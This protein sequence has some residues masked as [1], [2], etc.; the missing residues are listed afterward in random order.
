MDCITCKVMV[1]TG[2]AALNSIVACMLRRGQIE[3]YGEGKEGR[4]VTPSL[5]RRLQW[6]NRDR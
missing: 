2:P 4:L 1:V 5:R 3:L 6:I